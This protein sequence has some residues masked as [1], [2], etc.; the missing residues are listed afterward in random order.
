MMLESVISLESMEESIDFQRKLTARI[1]DTAP[2]GE[3]MALDRLI[4]AFVFIVRFLI[5]NAMNP[6]QNLSD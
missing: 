5:H 1:P 4:R 2:D 6:L 3:T